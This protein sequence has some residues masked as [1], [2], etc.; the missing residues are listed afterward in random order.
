MLLVGASGRIFYVKASSPGSRHDS[1]VFKAS[2]LYQ[3]LSVEGWSPIHNGIIAA[4]SGYA[5]H[6]KFMATPFCEA[7]TD[8]REREYNVRFCRAR[9]VVEQAI[10]RLKNR[11]RV[12]LGDGIRLRNM[13]AAARIIQ[14]ACALNNFIM[15]KCE[16][17]IDIDDSARDYCDQF[18]ESQADW[19]TLP[20]SVRCGRVRKTP[21]KEKLLHKYF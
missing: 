17:P 9:V 6:H 19:D 12:L 3:K 15:E 7:T 2:G 21:T 20:D 13:K 5:G 1:A 4:D 14:I 16:E 11:W 8:K 18:H 10:G